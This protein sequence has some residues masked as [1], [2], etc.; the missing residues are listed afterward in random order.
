[1]SGLA[2]EPAPAAPA[3]AGLRLAAVALAAA[4]TVVVVGGGG[5]YF[6][7]RHF[8]SGA[9]GG[10]A[11]HSTN[12]GDG[13]SASVPALLA[14]VA[15]SLVEVIREPADGSEPGAGDISSGFVAGTGLVVT[16]EG[17]VAGAA[18]VEVAMDSGQVVGATIAAADPDTGVVVL[19]VSSTSLPPPLSFAAT[20]PAAGDVALAVSFPVG[21]SPSIDVGTVSAIGLTLTVPDLAAP[22]GTTELDGVLRTDTSQ[23]QGSSGGPLLDSSGAVIG[24]LTGDRMEPVDLGGNAA[25]AGFAL[26]ASAASSLVSSLLDTGAV[27]QPVGLVCRWLAP[28]SAAALNLPAGAL[29]LDVDPGST[30]AAAGLQPGDVVTQVGGSN[31]AASAIGSYPSLSDLLQAQGPGAVA[32]L[33]VVRAGTTHQL[34]LTLPSP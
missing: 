13:G 4:I 29:V 25:A 30:A 7:V 27:P 19:Q 12:P 21:S 33:S 24:V 28:A 2:P 23:P 14:Q 17:A 1:M 31:L 8:D 22:G 11:V 20:A 9:P 26:D 6:L 18:G 15:P 3:P 10:A 5:A 34:S 32:H 16:S